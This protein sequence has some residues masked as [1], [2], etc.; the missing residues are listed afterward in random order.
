M[1]IK[2]EK[3]RVVDGIVRQVMNFNVDLMPL[4][5]CHSFCE[6]FIKLAFGDNKIFLL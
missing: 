1:D 6:W 4:Y 3:I 2:T 5:S